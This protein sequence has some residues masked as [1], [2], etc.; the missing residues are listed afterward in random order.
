MLK[1]KT[2]LAIGI[3]AL[4]AGLAVSPAS[5]RLKPVTEIDA[6]SYNNQGRIEK[7]TFRLTRE[8]LTELNS[9]LTQLSE[10]L[11]T[12]GS[13]TEFIDILDEFIRGYGR[14]PVITSLMRLF[15]KT[16][17]INSNM[18]KLTP[19]RHRAFI[20]SWGFS[21]K[22]NPM[23][24]TEVNLFRPLT[25]WYY[26][27]RN[28]YFTNSRSII[29]DPYPFNIKMMDGRQLGMMRNFVG[30]YLYGRT[31]GDKDF[32]FMFGHAAGVVGMDLSLSFDGAW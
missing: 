18:Y 5:A 1:M 24:E 17:T 22:L 21:N 28:K 23:K 3:I 4:F 12:A 9:V 16:T 27:G 7:T 29:V 31:L 6:F 8:E 19:F 2:L 25:F 26:T 30:V 14:Y 10:R 32:T 11:Q 13:Y 20:M 15:I